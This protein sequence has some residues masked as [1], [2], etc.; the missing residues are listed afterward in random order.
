MSNYFLLILSM[1]F[2]SISMA[3]GVEV[4]PVPGQSIVDA[5]MGFLSSPTGVIVGGVVVEFALRFI[6]SEKPLGV[7][8]AIGGMLKLFGNL[9]LKIG[10]FLDKVLPQKLK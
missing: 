1:L 10:E 4:E 6:K 8:H 7:I 9:A 3:F 5:I 2:I